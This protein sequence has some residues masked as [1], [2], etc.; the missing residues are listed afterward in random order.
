[1]YQAAVSKRADNTIHSGVMEESEVC[2]LPVGI[3]RKQFETQ[4]RTT[5]QNV[6]QFHFHHRTVQETSNSEVTVSSSS[7]HVVPGSQHLDFNQETMVSYSNSNLASGYENHQHETEEDEFPRYTTK[8]LRDRF[9]RTIEEAAP[10][11]TVKIG[12]DINRSKWSSNVTQNNVV[13][14]EV[15]EASGTE[16]KDTT[17]AVM[18]YADFPPPPAEDSDYLPP[19]PP[20]LLQM[21]LEDHDIP[22]SRYSP[23]PP[24]MP[25]P[26][27]PVNRDAHFKQRSMNELKRL[28]KHIHPEVRKNI[29]KDYSNETESN[30]FESKEYVYEDD[31]GSP[32]EMN[33]DEY[34]EWEDVLPGEVQAL[35][36]RFENKALDT[37]RNET[38]DDDDD[39]KKIQQEIILGKDVR[40]TAWMF[41]TK[42]IKELGSQNPNS[43]EYKN[44]SNKLD[45]GD[46][47]AAAWLFETQTMDTLNKIHKEEDLTKEIV[48]T[49]EDE[50]ATIYMIDS[51]YMESLGHTETIDES[52]LLSL[53]AVLE[54]INEDV[55]TV[56]STFDTQFKC[57]LMGQS[58]QML[59]IKSVRKI[60]TELE[61]SIGSRWLFD[62]QPLDMANREPTP[63]KLVCSLSM[64]D[65]NKGDWG[66]WLFEIKTLNSLSEW[67]CSEMEKKEI[68]GADV[69]KHCLVFETQTI[70]SLKDESNTRSQCLEEI[71]G[72]NVRSARNFFESSPQV[73][74]K[75]CPEVG[76]LKKATVNEEVKG[77]VRHQKWRFESQPLEYIRDEKKEIT[78]TVNIEEDLTQED[79]TSCR[80]DVRKNCWVFETQPMDTLKDDSNTRSSQKEEIIAGN[81]RSAR[82][83]FETIPTD[84]LK[85]LAEVGKLKK[86]VA[87]DE[88]KG[89]V[90]HQKWRFECQPLVGIQ[91][92][93]EVIRTIDLEEIDKVDVS[94]YKQIFESTDLTTRDESQK[95]L[96]EGVKSGSVKSNKNLFESTQLYAMEDSSGHIHEVRTVRR[97]EVVKGDVTTCKWM[98]ETR[99]ID[100]F[101]E[102]MTKYQI[103]KGISK[104][105]I[106]SG[107]VKTAKWL[108]ETQPLDAIKYFSNIEDE[109]NVVTCTNH[110]IMRGDVK[111]CKWLFE[112][113]PMEDL[114]ERVEIKGDSESKEMSKGDVKTC[115]WLFE[116]QALDMIHDE[117]ETVLKTCTVNQEDITG[118]DVRTACFL[119]ETEKLENLTGEE[120]DSFKRVTQIDI[121][122]GDVSRMKYV[123]ENQ[124]SDIMTSTSEE[125][126]QKLKR[127]QTEEMQKGNVGTCKWLFENQSIDTIHDIQEESKSSRTV[128][129]VQGGDVDKGRLIFETYSL[130]KIHEETDTEL[131]KMQRIV[132]DKDEMGDV[133]NY[134]MM[135]E[136]QPLYAIQDKEGHYHEV[137]TVTSEEVTRG[138]VVGTR[139]LFETKPLDAIKD[140]DE[141]YIIK[142]V[143]QQD[144]QKGD[145]SSA[146]WKFETQPLDRIAEEKKTLIKTVDDIQGGNVRMNKHR[147]ES[148]ALSQDSV[149][150]VN[151]SEIQ[152]G[153]VRTAK[154]RF[155]TQSIDKIRSMS[156]E[157]LIES[158]KKEEVA[159]GDV[160][161]SVWLFEKNPLDHI[162]EADENEET[163][164]T[165]EEIPKADV[166]TTRCLF[167]TTPFDDFNE[168]KMEKTEI[169]GK[170]VKGTLEELYSQKMVT[171]KGILIE[172]DE[173]GDVRMAKFQLMNTQ[174]PEIQREEVIR[175]D[176]QTIMMNLLNRQ[177]RNE[178]QIVIDSEEKGNISTT[179]QQLFNQDRDSSVEREEILRGD[180]QEAINNLFSADSLA[181]HGI[182]IQEDE[183]GD[184]QMTIY[185]LL[186]QQQNITLE[187]EDIVRG[188]I[189][190]A[191]QRLSSADKTGQAVKIKVD[192]AEKGNVNFYSTC[193]ESGAMEYLKQLHLGPDDTSADIV[194]KEKIV[195]GDIKGTKLILSHNQMQ[196]E[197]TV[198]DVI[199]GDV[200]NTVKVFMSEPTVSFDRQKEEIVRG[201]LRAALNSL[202]QSANQTVVVEKEEVIK[203]N[204]PKT[205]LCLEKCQKR[206]KDV[207]KPDIIPGNIKGT[208]RSLEKSA[209]SKVKVDVEELVAGDVKASLKS[210]ELAKQAVR[211][212]EKEEIVRGD[213]HTAMQNLQDASNERITCQQEIDVQGD[214]RGT[215]QLFMEPPSSPT[216][217]RRS[218]SLEGE[219]KGDVKMS[220]K[221]LY[222]TQEQTQLGK[223]EVIK[224]DVKGTIKSL[225]ETAQRE[226]PKV[227]LGSHRRVRVKQSPPVKNLNVDTQRNIQKIKTA[228]SVETSKVNKS[229]NETQTAGVKSSTVVQSSQ[230]STTVVEHKTITQKHD[231]K[232]V[233]TEFRNLKSSSKG[234]KKTKVKTDVYILQSQVPEPDLPLPPPPVV[235][236]E[237]PPP[238]PP[239][240]PPTV[241]SDI[242]HLPPPP[243]PPPLTS[244]E[245]FLPPPPSQQELESLPAQAIH[246]AKA[247]KMTVKKVKAPAL[248]PVP[249][250][251]TKVEFSKTQQM[252]ATSA[253]VVEINQ[254]QSEMTTTHSKTV[255]CKIP[256]L[257][258]SPQPLKK[259]YFSPVKFTPPP[260]P[261]PF[262]RGK[263]SKFTT[264]L[265]KA[266]EKFRKQKEEN[267]PPTTPTPTYI[268]DSVTA[269]LE[270]LSNNNIAEITQQRADITAFNVDSDSLLYD[271][272]K[273]AVSTTHDGASHEK[274]FTDSSIMSTASQEIV[275]NEMSKVISIQKTSSA[276]SVR[277]HVHT[278]LQ[279]TD[280]FKQ[281]GAS[282]ITDKVHTSNTDV[283][284]AG[285][286][287]A[288]RKKDS[289]IQT[290]KGPNRAEDKK[291][292]KMSNQIVKPEI[293]V[294]AEVNVKLSTSQSESKKT[295]DKASKLPNNLQSSKKANA[296]SD[297]NVKESKS[298]QRESKK[299]N[300]HSPTTSQERV[301]DQPMQMTAA[302]T[303]GKTGKPNQKVKKNN[304]QEKQLEAKLSSESEKQ[305]VSEDLKV[306]TTDTKVIR[307][308]EDVKTELQ[309]IKKVTA[310]PATTSA[311]AVTDIISESQQET[312]TPT[313]KKKKSKK[314]KGSSPPG[315]GKDISIESKL[316]ATEIKTVMPEKSHQTQNTV[317][318]S[319]IHKSRKEE[320]IQVMKEVTFTESKG[321]QSC[322]E[323]KGVPK[324]MKTSE[325]KK[326]RTVIQQSTE[327]PQQE[328]RAV[329]I[330]VADE[331][332]QNKLATTG[333]LKESPLQKEIFTEIHDSKYLKTLLNNVPDWLISPERKCELEGSAVV[334]SDAHENQEIISHVMTAAEPKLEDYETMEKHECESVSEKGICG[335]A[336]ARISKIS[337]GSA[338]IENQ[339]IKNTSQEKRTE[340]VSQCKPFDFRALSP[341]LRMRS[342]SPTFITIESTRRTDSPQR[343]TPSPTLLH[344]PPTPPTPPPRRCDTPTSRL[345]RITPSPTF[346]RA[347]NL[348]RLKD[349][350]AKL[351]RGVTPPPLLSPQ[352]ISE[353]KS[354]IVES[355]ASFH[356][357]I[358][359]ESQVLEFPGMSFEKPK[360]SLSE[361]HVGE[362]LANIVQGLNASE[363]QSKSENHSL[364]FQND[365]DLI[366]DSDMSEPSAASV[367]EKREFFEEA[368]KA[369]IKKAYVR[370]EPIA[371][372][373]RL[374]PDLEGGVAENLKKEKDELPRADLSGL[375]NI[376]ESP[377]E[378][379][380]IKNEIIPPTEWLYSD[381]E[382]TDCDKEIVHVLEEGVPTFDIQAIK[383]VFELGEQSFSFREEEK[384]QEE[385]K[386]SLSETTVD[387][388]K[389]ESPQETKGGTQ[390]SIPLP[391]LKYDAEAVP[392]EPSAFSGAKSITE[393]FSD[394]DEFGNQVIGSRTAV[395]M[396]S[397]GV[398]TQK[399]P[400]SYADAVKQKT[401]AVRR[402]ETC[403]ED[404]TEKLLRNFHQTWSESEA[405]F[406]SLG[407]TV[408]EESTSQVISQQTT[409]SSGSSSEVGALRS[410]SEENLSNGCSDSGQKKVP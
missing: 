2:S 267:T 143:T 352:Q 288:D 402:T 166:K 234:M 47:R 23:E 203:G 355:P 74:R 232:T 213:I 291:E 301:S 244:E 337:I 281:S 194:E 382:S 316:E 334:K 140:T 249:K 276:S 5:S 335:G 19:P 286:I 165:Q 192:D 54:E 157:N 204:I 129:D 102:S 138:D 80:A 62:T 323:Q 199:P 106:E 119:F 168:T 86:S 156:S 142:S 104:Q 189:K 274:M 379:I 246:P 27:Y 299:K 6:T 37:I 269:A 97:E 69:R 343:V 370:K 188:D 361:A 184:V 278:T 183:K 112:T 72:G 209:T 137:T 96:I 115:T 391:L 388:S 312:P 275:S 30:Q 396:H 147:F 94:N 48:F 282:V 170:S 186:N 163:V 339:I 11:K 155:E 24:E 354:E 60:E 105:E 167:E 366:D 99:P 375:V 211:E 180:I 175:G 32:D 73:A 154:W 109:E 185:S 392:A 297:K 65:S 225:M 8:E 201:D 284:N 289:Q 305:T 260:S 253:K 124:T 380:Y 20:D 38:P 408:S 390:Q 398:S 300:D 302:N 228:K 12:R 403:D 40:H 264:P 214:V 350:M 150:T 241:D 70:D 177:E 53:R 268:H 153:D 280:S 357:Q 259:V 44:K 252:K 338:K 386:S 226:T 29:E 344:R 123:F 56:T 82:N 272:S 235:D 81:V 216:M 9:E 404:A 17:A 231:I 407:Y 68:T 164:V 400:F 393:H 384:D 331:S 83:Y 118:K 141:V 262:M 191:L 401:S 263:M 318:I 152:K 61:N 84:E 356:R 290:T 41:E 136:T 368:Q 319:Q 271:L 90:R 410:M 405:V 245:D 381:S 78:R 238:P 21:P 349:T 18:D 248:H 77:D 13:T 329:P 178:Q 340:D 193:I 31:G 218:P 22:D 42:P 230:Q 158:V 117:S 195:G 113:K 59:E 309:R 336:T 223:E 240:P 91:R 389:L 179:V 159:K 287:T 76:K 371:I 190:R 122:S 365:P 317:A 206:S 363:T 326:A 277:Q 144:V 207:E 233:K 64:E 406:K 46:V 376:F 236:T 146:K 294:N 383:N 387:T 351:S 114:N 295:A 131:M 26:I 239:P 330:T 121:A 258:E 101:D 237:L 71:I 103:I 332:E 100:Q 108:F 266:E 377:Q 58:S 15:Y 148:D 111:T 219:V 169:L 296:I 229:L 261:P 187:K 210:L 171:S 145:V 320:H 279:K 394:V 345:T 198:E 328:S 133:R 322:Q 333:T 327:E 93:K 254:N 33:D 173:I 324:H 270:M 79:G 360:V 306:K 87:L 220:I 151:V 36:W 315:K 110:D 313:K 197:R 51:K 243:P 314:S 132:C 89:D 49:E 372:P 181:K 397:E 85:E 369:E 45:K 347:E 125:V 4:E 208:L 362:E 139:W 35:R 367:K 385:P 293:S 222:E 353:K 215:I 374:G 399:A 311:L 130:D 92:K 75:N 242:D 359:I 43:T 308:S 265:I 95:I 292:D 205:L 98:F 285:N 273:H 66:R 251:E 88:E 283:A 162:K 227:R 52:H 358:K 3:V 128:N 373:E 16:S 1:M 307:E 172:S 149:R 200:H 257:P 255:S 217:Q 39:V 34:G 107:D 63:L 127:V 25:N 116:T 134:T 346:D 176:L 196:I 298:P 348:A 182:L 7:S 310:S 304:K 55:K 120:S 28:Y 14:C 409:F 10:Q 221:S 161:N 303:D 247:K 202:S 67:E 57:I 50:N 160:K 135:F 395:T 341:L 250:L 212:V 174:A 364:L 256:P 342:P 321:Q 224:G 378:K 325:K 126:M